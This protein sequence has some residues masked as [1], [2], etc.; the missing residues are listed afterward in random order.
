M[1]NS[2]RVGHTNVKHSPSI[3]VL[4]TKTRI[5]HCIYVYYMTELFSVFRSVSLVV[6]NFTEILKSRNSNTMQI[7][8]QRSQLHTI[9]ASINLRS[10]VLRYQIW[11]NFGSGVTYSCLRI[12]KNAF[13]YLKMIPASTH[14]WYCSW[15]FILYWIN[16]HLLNPF[17]VGNLFQPFWP[18]CTMIYRFPTEFFGLWIKIGKYELLYWY[19][20]NNFTQTI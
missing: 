20:H 4:T 11:A 7:W 15:F 9:E 1:W 13:G 17:F 3:I 6:R 12:S 19:V 8:S 14:Q 18:F 5:N 2:Y 16:D 10:T